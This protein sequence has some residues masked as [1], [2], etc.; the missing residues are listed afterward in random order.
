MKTKAR[1]R[2][3]IV[4]MKR[5]RMLQQSAPPNSGL[6]SIAPQPGPQYSSSAA[7]P[8]VIHKPAINQSISQ[9]RLNTL[10]VHQPQ[11][12]EN[13]MS[14]DF[15]HIQV[16]ASQE[17]KLHSN[18]LSPGR[19]K[20][21]E[22][23]KIFDFVNMTNFLEC[24]SESQK[25]KSIAASGPPAASRSSQD[26]DEVIIE[27]ESEPLEEFIDGNFPVSIYLWKQLIIENAREKI[28][29]NKS[30]QEKLAENINKILS[31]DG[32]VTQA[33]KQTESGPTEQ[34]TSIDEILGLQLSEPAQGFFQSP[35]CKMLLPFNSCLKHCIGFSQP[36]LPPSIQLPIILTPGAPPFAA[37]SSH[38]LNA[39]F[40]SCTGREFRNS[41]TPAWRTTYIHT[42]SHAGPHILAV[43]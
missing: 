17:R 16:P 27:K 39:G 31:S 12:Q 5:Q 3:G 30:L 14:R 41:L 25:R 8:Q 18:L 9:A 29:S 22:G 20:S 33:P 42:A 15:I 36:L 37:S 11:A 38:L 7:S 4:E 13:K 35:C 34:E 24:F 6:L 40:G 21:S 10:F 19:R 43:R 28:L 23:R 2:S 26:P 32:N 1:T